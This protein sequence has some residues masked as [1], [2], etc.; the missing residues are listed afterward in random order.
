M[1]RQPKTAPPKSKFKRVCET[2]LTV[3]SVRVVD[4]RLVIQCPQC[5]AGE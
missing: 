1:S 4:G 2:C 5:Q 3:L